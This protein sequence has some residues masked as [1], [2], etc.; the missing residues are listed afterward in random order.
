MATADDVLGGRYRLEGPL[1]AGGMATVHRAYDLLL[2]RQVA[3]KILASNVAAS[4]AHLERFGREARAMATITHPNLVAIYDVGWTDD[5]TGRLP[6][7]VMELVSGGTLAQRLA[8]DG[9]LDPPAVVA[10][11][12]ALASALDALH[13]AGIIHRDVKTQNVLLAENGPKLADL[14]IV[15]VDDPSDPDAAALTVSGS[16]PGTLR[17]LAPEVIFGQPAGPKSDAYALAMVAYEAITGRSPRPA[18]TLG[19]LVQGAWQPPTPVSEARPELGTAF[20]AV[21]AAALDLDPY[22]RLEP[23]AFAAE[24]WEAVTAWAASP[25]GGAP[26][27]PAI[28][29]SSV[30]PE[31][32]TAPAP[33]EPADV[34]VPVTAALPAAAAADLDADTM[35]DTGAA[36]TDVAALS[37]VAR[38]NPA[39]FRREDA[40]MAAD[41]PPPARATRDGDP[42]F[43]V[44][45]ALG[46]LVLALGGIVLALLLLRPGSETGA[47]TPGPSGS[48]TPS[49][50][51]PSS[52]VAP[53]STPTSAATDD[54]A[55]EARR[56][57]AAVRTAIEAARGGKDGL[58]GSEANELVALADEVGR[59]LDAGDFGTASGRADRLADRAEK[60]SD[61]LDK[62][63]REALK[64]AIED[65]R[66]SIPPA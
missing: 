2:G 13:R 27:G 45:A 39:A 38:L 54:I 48:G 66:A 36:L 51:G 28:A 18:L 49:T 30:V 25:A 35:A 24:L 29:G 6:F 65:L 19:E 32:S 50:A 55:A 44:L 34:A 15:R 17:S 5:Q 11:V 26:A 33:D 59:A 42:G 43:R 47:P 40:A 3:V 57:L 31:P 12:E 10:L 4:P 56:A 41:R 22:R 60:V 58:N 20:D 16:I 9:P 1:G 46:V 52:T 23:L 61:D 53:T 62:R 63:R 8:A 21:F 37:G 14:G 7:L 64:A